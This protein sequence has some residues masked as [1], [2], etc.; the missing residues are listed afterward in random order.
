M[1][2][3]GRKSF[4]KPPRA[5]GEGF[6]NIKAAKETF[7][8]LTY[9]IRCLNEL[10]NQLIPQANGNHRRASCSAGDY[11]DGGPQR[12]PKVL[13]QLRLLKANLRSKYLGN[14]LLFSSLEHLKVVVMF[15]G[16]KQPFFDFRLR[17]VSDYP[18]GYPFLIDDNEGTI[19]GLSEAIYRKVLKAVQ[20]E[21]EGRGFEEGD[22]NSLNRSHNNSHAAEE[23]GM[24]R[25]NVKEE[26]VDDDEEEEE[27]VELI[28]LD[29]DSEDEMQ[30]E[31]RYNSQ[32]IPQG[33]ANSAAAASVAVPPA[34][35]AT[36]RGHQMNPRRLSTT[37]FSS[38]SKP[39]SQLPLS[40]KSSNKR[41]AANLN[42]AQPQGN[43]KRAKTSTAP[44][45]SS[46]TRAKTASQAVAEHFL[47]SADFRKAADGQKFDC[48]LCEKPY[49]KAAMKD[50]LEL[51]HTNPNQ[52]VPYRC[53]YPG[54]TYTNVW[55]V[56]ARAHARREHNGEQYIVK[57]TAAV[58]VPTRTSGSPS[59]ASSSSSSSAANRATTT[60]S[61]TSPFTPFASTSQQH[62]Q[63]S[64]S[65]STS[66]ST[67]QRLSAEDYLRAHCPAYVAAKNASTKVK[68]PEC[69][70]SMYKYLL[71]KHFIALHLRLKPY[72]CQ[73]QGCSYTTGWRSN[74]A[75]H[76]K[77]QH[78]G[79]Y[80]QYIVYRE[81]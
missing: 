59:L 4:A 77:E 20:A 79:S 10:Y 14:P 44:K 3:V 15:D 25:V 28:T 45:T 47:A 81:E 41:P 76:V 38:K 74:A 36:V 16:Q 21:K 73:W 68:C 5:S 29:D 33:S 8:D 37:V 64:T 75:R 60:A 46:S 53:T 6:E 24:I 55:G 48:P 19:V 22:N 1:S 42:A 11:Q 61:T 50:H 31:E 34:A 12:D 51:A 80:P 39:H 35:P 17:P 78:N 63:P 70:K 9:Q 67:A 56:N 32:G 69:S 72:Q 23:E 65:A 49:M 13:Q 18:V 52:Y 40:H 43:S 7:C 54:C 27:V 57:P 2:S 71:M 66:A 62:Q 30:Q 26:E 58:V